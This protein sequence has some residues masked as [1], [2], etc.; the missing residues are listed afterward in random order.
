MK[1]TYLF[2]VKKNL[3][4]LAHTKPRHLKT[5]PNRAITFF[6]LQTAMQVQALTNTDFFNRPWNKRVN[7]GMDRG[8]GL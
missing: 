7:V 2:A 5:K 4:K 3:I 8:R 6:I 1:I